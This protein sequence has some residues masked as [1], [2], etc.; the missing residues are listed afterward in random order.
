MSVPIT[1]TNAGLAELVSASGSGTAA[2]TIAAIG[3]SATAI[4]P[5]AT[6]TAL[7]GEL[8]RLTSISGSN[9]APDTIH[10]VMQDDS[11]N[12]Y[13]ALAFGLYLADG[14]LFAVYGQATP[15]YVKTAA[16]I[17]MLAIDVTFAAAD[18]AAITFGNADF[19]NPPAT[20]TVKG[21]VQLATLAQA[22][23]GTDTTDVLTPATGA[24]AVMNWVLSRDGAGSALDADL[25]QGKTPAQFSASLPAALFSSGNNA[26]G[27][28]EKRPDGNGGFI[29][30]QW[31][32]IGPFYG[33]GGLTWTFPI[34]FPTACTLVECN[35]I[36][37]GSNTSMDQGMQPCTPTRDAVEIFSQIYGGG[38][39]SFPCTAFVKA[40]GH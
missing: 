23:A 22:Q 3:V 8:H 4:T 12:A 25:W 19:I 5:A 21:V 34:E 36:N 27:W 24:G 35:V 11:A 39:S 16:S 7:P 30:E 17:G 2:I 1:L 29:I 18:A 38:S 13:S 6:M 32:T 40:K 26:N 15:I 20:T 28:W 9:V 14:T 31:G 33:E 10:V 37:N